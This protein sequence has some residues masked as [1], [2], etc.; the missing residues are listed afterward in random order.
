MM[1][2]SET[3]PVVVAG[4]L[5]LDILSRP[6]TALRPGTSN[7]AQTVFSPGGVGR[8]LA[9]NL[10]QLGAPVR[11][12]G[13]VGDDTFGES[14]LNQ[15]RASGVDVSGV[16]T[17]P[18]STGSYLAVLDER[19]E[20]HCGLSSMALTAALTPADA[21]HWPKLLDA[22]RLLIVDAN[23]PAPL[24]D[25]LLDAARQRNLRVVLEPVSAPKAADLRFLLSPRRP[26]WL[27]TPDRAEL[28]AL[29]GEESISDEPDALIHASRRLRAF[30]AEWV[31]VTLGRSGSLL[32]GEGEPIVTPARQAQ[33]HDVTGA[34]DAFLAGL[35]AGFEL[36]QSW[37]EALHQAHLC[38]A[39]TIEVGGAVR[40]DLSVELLGRERGRA[41]L[42][43]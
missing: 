24:V 33:V 42:E 28:A 11:L 10:A 40:G 17:R 1:P 5:N 34:G 32:V 20:L 15:T 13:V 37:P 35:I 6:Y 8:N 22:A 21:A 43:S 41:A 18:G 29:V 12:L 30:G 7:P 23:L 26:L 16:L 2:A 14:L 9:Q 38:A 25:F 36:S 27:V 3:G 31:L 39:L 4:G 19:G